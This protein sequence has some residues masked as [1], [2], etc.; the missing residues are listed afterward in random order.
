MQKN[1]TLDHHLRNEWTAANMLGRVCSRLSGWLVHELPVLGTGSQFQ[2][3]GRLELP[4]AHLHFF[5]RR[6]GL[7]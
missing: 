4:R 2:L 3:D 5:A 6:L 1:A 7:G